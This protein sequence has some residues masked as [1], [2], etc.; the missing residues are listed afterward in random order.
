MYKK[1][2]GVC[3]FFAASMGVWAQAP[4]EKGLQSISRDK[5]EAIV[6]FL[7]DDNLLGREAGQR[8]S[9][10]VAR[11]LVSELKEAGI[12]PLLGDTYYQPFEATF[13]STPGL[14]GTAQ[15][16]HIP[17]PEAGKRAGMDTRRTG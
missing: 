3:C 6:E 16:R 8:E 13:P 1:I 14:G 4:V 17:Q 12:R 10:I 9:R 15:A 2:L 7:A 5:A 11:Y